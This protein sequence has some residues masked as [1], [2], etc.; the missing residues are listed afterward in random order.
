MRRVAISLV[1]LVL[2]LNIPS[3]SQDAC[4]VSGD[5]VVAICLPA[6]GT[7]PTSPIHIQLATNDS[8]ATVDLL[9]V[10]YNQVKRWEKHTSAADFYLQA[11]GGGPYH[12][13]AVAH[14]TMGRWFQSSVDVN[15]TLLDLICNPDQIAGQ[16]PHSMVECIPADGEIHQSPVHV[17]W[18]ALPSSGATMKG[19]VIYVDGV[20]EFST[21]PALRNGF[22]LPDVDLPLAV[23]QHRI[24]VKGYDGTTP[25]ADSHIMKV[26]KIYQGCAPPTTLPG[27]VLCSLTDGQT[28]NGPVTIKASAAT[29]YGI[30]Q[31]QT[32][33]DGA[34]Q[35]TTFHAW[36]DFGMTLASGP[37]TIEVLAIDYAKNQY[38]VTV[39]ITA[40]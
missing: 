27:I 38:S 8:A 29:S 34:R 4:S 16:P 9:Q 7:S 36:A 15:I 26:S 22:P 40:Q 28:V 12:I 39:N 5:P 1:L 19:L 37:H 21:P 30:E 23:G 32:W 17:S 2:L 13:T 11:Q 20:R 6:A 35:N 18:D 31:I 14:D 24:T 10:Y 33:V 3:F 25:F